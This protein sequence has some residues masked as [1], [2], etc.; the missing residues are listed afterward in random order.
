MLDEYP[1]IEE[2]TQDI[3][4]DPQVTLEVPRIEDEQTPQMATLKNHKDPCLTSN[5]ESDNTQLQLDPANHHQLNRNS[6]KTSVASS[7]SKTFNPSIDSKNTAF[8]G[9]SNATDNLHVGQQHKVYPTAQ[10]NNLQPVINGPYTS[11]YNNNLDTSSSSNLHPPATYQKSLPDNSVINTPTSYQYKK[12]QQ[13][14]Q[15]SFPGQSTHSQ[16]TASLNQFEMLGDFNQHHMASQFGQ[17]GSSP[18]VQDFSPVK[19]QTYPRDSHSHRLDPPAYP[20]SSA[21][22]PVFSE[23]A[24]NSDPMGNPQ[25]HYLPYTMQDHGNV[26]PSHFTNNLF[27]IVPQLDNVTLEEPKPNQHQSVAPIQAWSEHSQSLPRIDLVS[28]HIDNILESDP[29]S[30]NS[31]PRSSPPPVSRELK[32]HLNRA[33]SHPPLPIHRTSN[34]PYVK[35]HRSGKFKQFRF[36][37]ISIHSFKI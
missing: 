13:Q 19:S 11:T 15:K 12:H 3:D 1:S 9:P 31:T 36:R 24:L 32:P 25:T 29:S 2:E 7:S 22:R 33:E 16:Y 21:Y 20:A 28:R 30:D 18:D 4:E 6:R 8:I 5:L 14:R 10:D 26:P 23:T 35:R 34:Q 37:Y 27:D 17:T